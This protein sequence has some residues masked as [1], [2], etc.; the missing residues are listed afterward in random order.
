MSDVSDRIHVLVVPA[1]EAAGYELVDTQ[2]KREPLGWIV[3]LLIDKPG[4]VSHEDCARVSREVSVLLDVHDVVPHAYHLEVSSPGLDRPLRTEAHFRGFIGKRAK[5][6]LHRGL[7]GRRN[8]TGIVVR[9]D[10]G[11]VILDVDGQEQVLPLADLDQANLVPEF[12]LKARKA[13][14]DRGGPRPARAGTGSGRPPG[15]QR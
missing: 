15:Q 10:P 5:V 1:V 2:W 7:D 6:K 12:D 14:G 8:F 3:R 4:G 11:Q 9:V 13:T